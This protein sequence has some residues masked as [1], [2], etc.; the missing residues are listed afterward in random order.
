MVSEYRPDRARM[1]V[2]FVSIRLG[3]AFINDTESFE[4]FFVF[5]CKVGSKCLV[6]VGQ[7][8]L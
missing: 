7:G 4:C 6:V 3:R 5:R 2:A 8:V 1:I